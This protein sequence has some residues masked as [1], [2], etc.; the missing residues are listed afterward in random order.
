[1]CGEYWT[2]EGDD[3]D[4]VD[5]DLDLGFDD[6]DID[7]GADG[8]GDGDGDVDGTINLSQVEGEELRE[9]MSLSS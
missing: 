6:N 2:L 7:A 5:L 9:W 1:M 4:E 8:D 3:L